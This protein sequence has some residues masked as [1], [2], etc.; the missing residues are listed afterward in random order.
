MGTLTVNVVGSFALSVIAFMNPG[1]EAYAFLGTGVLGGFTTFSTFGFETFRML[2]DKDY[3]TALAN[4]ALNLVG[5]LLAIY[6]GYKIL[7]LI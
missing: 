4:V 2:E 1:N 5:G 6:A 7:T 3:D